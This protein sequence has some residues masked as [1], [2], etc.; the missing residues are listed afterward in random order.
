MQVLR[1]YLSGQRL[2]IFL[3][4]GI[5][6]LVYARALFFPHISW[7][8][9]E[10]L[11]SNRDVKTFDLAALFS[12]QYVGNYIPVTM[13]LHALAYWCFGDNDLLH[14]LLNLSLHLCNALLVY[15]LSQELFRNT[16]ISL[17]ALLLFVL[18]PLQVE[19]VMWIS[20]LKNILSAF[21]SL[22][23]LL[24]WLRYRR[25]AS[26]KQLAF[27]L[28]CFILALLSKP[29]AVVFPLLVLLLDWF[30][31]QG[32]TKKRLLEYLPL[33]LLSVLFAYITLQTQ[34]A[35]QFIN[36]SHEF[37]WWQ[38]LAFAGLALL[39]YFRLFLFPYPLSIIYPYPE[40]K[41]LNFIAGICA[42][43]LLSIALVVLYRRQKR[44]DLFALCFILINF[45]L[46]LQFIPFGEVLYADRY[47]YMPLV[48]FAWLL[49]HVLSRLRLDARTWLYVLMPLLTF[50]TYSRSAVW[51]SAL[52]LYE[53]ILAI[54]PRSFVALN[55]AGIECMRMDRDKK[56]LDYFNR[57]VKVKPE[58]YKTH[59]NRGLIYLKNQEAAKAIHD[60][61]TCLSI[62]EYHK[63]YTAR[64]TAYL[65]AGDL[66]KARQDANRALELNPANAKANFV[67][68]NVYER[69]GQLEEAMRHYNKS[70]ALEPEE[71]D[72]YFKRAILYGKQQNFR[73]CREDLD[74]CILLRPSFAEAYYW[75]GVARINLGE[76]ACEDFEVA[77][78]NNFEPAV[79]AFHTYCR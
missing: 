31:G 22:L 17:L 57:S 41:A 66:P 10:M 26:G 5:C 71:A 49:G 28:L 32:F 47:A 24:A 78:R 6:L 67:L 62:Y 9:P 18:H 2:L 56:A 76:K 21:F 64:A 44:S 53:N 40:G 30:E 3:C 72:Y 23:A 58:N 16:R 19:T 79:N 73:A 48:G 51:K 11:F 63:A 29:S 52:N 75:R 14:H 45:I 13:L 74:L 7:D 34:S 50:T 12:T 46:V 65:L 33:L 61:N 68:G 38:R 27:S 20:E 69:T 1:A 60:F 54:Y 43:L 35:A 36:R 15:R 42:W 4:L 59:Y 37:P 8:D 70:I 77:A 55:S 39:N 25:G